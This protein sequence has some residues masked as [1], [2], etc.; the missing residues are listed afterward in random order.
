[1]DFNIY[2]LIYSSYAIHSFLH[3]FKI[4]DFD[5]YVYHVLHCTFYHEYCMYTG[6]FFKGLMALKRLPCFK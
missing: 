1:M 3:C 4:F 6:L 2:F 5:V